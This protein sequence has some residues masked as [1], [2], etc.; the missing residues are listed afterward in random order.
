MVLVLGFV[1]VWYGLEWLYF[2][3]GVLLFAIL[4]AGL[5][6]S[7]LNDEESSASQGPVKEDGKPTQ[8][9]VVQPQGGGGFLDYLFAKQMHDAVSAKKNKERHEEHIEQLKEQKKEIE[10]LH[11]PLKKDK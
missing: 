6:S 11:K 5:S 10:K 8:V 1:A 7:E 2:A 3:V 9:V 4:F